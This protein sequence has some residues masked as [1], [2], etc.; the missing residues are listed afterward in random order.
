MHSC[1]HISLPSKNLEETIR[2]Y[3]EDLGLEIGRTT[4]DW[5][6]V[7]LFG[8]Q[9]TFVTTMS[10]EFQYPFYSLENN[11]IP[12]FHFG[13]VL[14]QEE[15]E[16][17]YDRINRWSIDTIIKTTFFEDKNGEQNSFFVQ[18]PNNYFIEFK[19]FKRENEIF[20]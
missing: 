12:T 19:T 4:E 7:N 8:N 20:I 5:A 6:D 16:D 11:E 9:I 15:W 1:F 2:Y 13:V 3:K 10:Y 17:M 14:E 18:D